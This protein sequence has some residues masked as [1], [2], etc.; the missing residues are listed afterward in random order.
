MLVVFAVAA[1]GLCACGGDRSTPT[2]GHAPAAAAAPR[3]IDPCSGPT[4][5]ARP[6]HVTASGQRS[7]VAVVGSGA[8]AV[9]FANQSGDSPCA[10]L[11]LAQRLVGEGATAYLTE[12][13]AATDDS[14]VI[15]AVARTAR[16]RGARRVVLVGASLG[17]RVVVSV[18]AR[19]P[20]LV[21]A[22]ASLSG[23]RMLHDPVDLLPDARRVRAP[24]LWAGT[25]GDG[26]TNFGVDTKQLERATR[27]RST[28]VLL[29]HRDEHGTDMLEGPDARR[30]VPAIEA[31]VRARR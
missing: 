18:A 30:V 14:S 4:R 26:Y 31:L 17:G 10:W 20:E 1:A 25:D 2:T 11:A 19:H 15:T 29:R 27:S 5:G 9:V 3:P 21:D 24:I 8:T 6:L 22:V 16:R 12:Y 28:L 23:E 13:G 7:N